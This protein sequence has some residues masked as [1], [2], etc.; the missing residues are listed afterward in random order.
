[1]LRRNGWADIFL[2]GTA[3]ER[4]VTEETARIAPLVGG[5]GGGGGGGTD[6]FGGIV[7]LGLAVSFVVVFRAFP[8]HHGAPAPHSWNRAALATLA[9]ALAVNVALFSAAGFVVASVTLFVITARAF[10]SR[11]VLR[12]A[13]VG[14]GLAV[15]IFIAFTR[16]LGVSLPAG[17]PPFG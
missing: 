1:L 7:L 11:R 4:F 13:L 5:G 17:P 3:F 14:I 9:L 8:R 10:G 2:A 16:G 6:Y 12:D 15:V